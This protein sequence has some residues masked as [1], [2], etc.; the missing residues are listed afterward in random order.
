M[1]ADCSNWG[2]EGSTLPNSASRPGDGFGFDS[3]RLH[4]E[5]VENMGWGGELL[6][7]LREDPRKNYISPSA[8]STFEKRDGISRLIIDEPGHAK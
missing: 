4:P 1:S 8:L 5:S 7:S 3:R 6:A 2:R